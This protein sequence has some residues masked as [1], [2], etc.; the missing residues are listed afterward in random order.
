M[1][2][3]NRLFGSKGVAST[4]SSVILPKESATAR[5]VSA[6]SATSSPSAVSLIIDELNKSIDA[7]KK[8][9]LIKDLGKHHRGDQVLHAI[10]RSLKD[11]DE[12]VRLYAVGT[13]Q[14]LGDARAA[15]PLIELLMTD[16]AHQPCYYATKALASLKTPRAISGMV[17]A[18]QAQKG[19]LSELAF[20]LGEVRAREAV[21]VLCNLVEGTG[22]GSAY[23]RRH[24]VISLAKIGDRRAISALGK[25]LSDADEG[26]RERAQNALNELS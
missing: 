4:P 18:L 10:V 19:D 22:G 13:L 26:V 5:S 11:P 6:V 17:L 7:G 12:K 23:A 15:E 1:A 8:C 25:A 21:E 14:D 2:F 16:T 9:Q 20:Q 3:W 24:A